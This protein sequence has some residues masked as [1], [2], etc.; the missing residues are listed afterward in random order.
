MPS[1]DVIQFVCLYYLYKVYFFDKQR[2][3]V[4]SQDI[5]DEYEDENYLQNFFDF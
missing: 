5:N 4:L 2:H 1:E 3:I